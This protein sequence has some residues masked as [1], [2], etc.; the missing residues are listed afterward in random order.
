LLSNQ[1]GK[2]RIGIEAAITLILMALVPVGIK[3][4]A[5]T[6][7]TI[8]VF[9]LAVAVVMMVAFLRPKS[10]S[11]LFQKKALLPL[12]LIGFFFAL[13]W[14]TYFLSIKKA[15]ASIGLLGMST[16][17]IHLIFLGWGIRKHK[18]GPFD[19][20]ALILATAG[21]YFII[22]EF[23]LTN[24]ITV[25]ILLGVFSGF[26]FA[27]LPVLHQQYSFIPERARILGQFLFA[28]LTFSFF[29]PVTDWQLES[30]DWWVLLYLAVGG[31]FIAHSLWVRV[32]TSVSTTVSSLIF[33]LIIPMTM[34]ISHFLLEEPMPFQKIAG[35][36]LI[37]SGN[38]VSF[39]GKIRMKKQPVLPD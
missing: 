24:N 10:L 17:G 36:V 19:I 34:L 13:H 38:V 6:P 39:A 18:P 1:D 9:R 28:L 12:I 30:M 27:L 23:S 8:A 15:T 3:L 5:A 32:T 20:L 26:C 7:I 22:P 33:Y 29:L 25:G 11:E 4:T 35:A 21:T 14:I 2:F 16:Y 37:V 31:T